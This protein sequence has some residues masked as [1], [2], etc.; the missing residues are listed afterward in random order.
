MPARDSE[1]AGLLLQVGWPRARY[2]A[3]MMV[4]VAVGAVSVLV[5]H[6]AGVFAETLAVRWFG[7]RRARLERAPRASATT[8]VIAA[9]LENEEKT[10]PLTLEQLE[11]SAPS[12]PKLVVANGH[13]RQLE[14]F[15][16]RWSNDDRH[17]F[18]HSP[19]AERK[20]D[21]MNVALAMKD[22]QSA[23]LLDADSHL[24]P[25]RLTGP[26]EQV[27]LSQF[28]KLMRRGSALLARL[29]ATE[30]AF[31]YFVTYPR[32]W[33][34]YRVAYFSGSG[35]VVDTATLHTAGMT[36]APRAL[37]EDID[38]SIR[39]ALR[40]LETEYCVDGGAMTTESVPPDWR[41]WLTQRR[42]WAGGWLQL[43]RWHTWPLLMANDHSVPYRLKWLYL[44]AFRRLAVPVATVVLLAILSVATAS[45][46]TDALVLAAVA[47]V[48]PVALLLLTWMEGIQVLVLAGRPAFADPHNRTLP[49]RSDVVA[50]VALG[51][52]YLFVLY[53]IDVSVILCPV[54]KWRTTR[55]RIAQAE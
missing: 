11:I 53:L 38:F 21:N 29:V 1:R 52:L 15:L 4:Y 9:R 20:A 24:V 7:G 19:A 5:G 42:R 49:T 36:F 27:P 48:W 46:A 17:R 23:L 39:C 37:V 30:M 28:P 10:L 3:K 22:I 40:G 51:W 54:R 45:R 47:A 14:S 43:C 18:C 12:L 34:L 33:Q 16:T 25:D 44:L 2:S 50:W 6:P 13:S 32:R 8:I 41:A 35:C 31:K 26:P 55:R